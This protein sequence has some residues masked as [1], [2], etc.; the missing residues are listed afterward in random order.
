[1]AWADTRARYRI[2]RNY[3]EQLIAG[4]RRDTVQKRYSTFENLTTYCYGVASTVGLMSMHIIGF[5]GPEAIPYAIK[6]GVALQLTNILRDVA[7]DLRS[8]RIYLPIEEMDAYGIQY[9]DL[10]AG[11][12]TEAWRAFMR[13]QI[14]RNRQLYDEAWPGIAMLSVGRTFCNCR[15]RRPLYR[16]ILDDIEDHD[17]DVFS[18]RAH[19]TTWGKLSVC[20]AFGGRP[21]P[22]TPMPRP[23]S[24]PPIP[25]ASAGLAAL[26]ALLAPRQATHLRA[27]SLLW[28]PFRNMRATSS[29]SRLPGFNMVVL[30]GPDAG[31]DLYVAK[32][33]QFSWRT[34]S[35]AVTQLLR[36]GI[37][38]VDGA[39]HDR[40]RA[41]MEPPRAS[42]LSP[43][44][45]PPLFVTQ[46]GCQAPGNP[47]LSTI[48]WWKC[49]GRPC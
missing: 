27:C 49:D 44:T 3:A 34:E 24:L 45:S 13:F 10:Q 36:R 39:E 48:C 7:E 28:P 32:R 12:V 43:P 26:R 35:D 18:R 17:Y 4:V 46:I 31:R 19:V 25:D 11:R 22:Y 42:T 1:M 40:L 33:H 29:R 5:A 8:D 38:V 16:G 9:A 30:T 2:P 37:L 14:Q 41:L 21:G 20:P 6:L 23:L 47:A 15:R